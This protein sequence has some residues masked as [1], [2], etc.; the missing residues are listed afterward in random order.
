[1]KTIKLYWKRLKSQT[2]LAL[3]KLQIFFGAIS[4]G[5]LA[6][7][8]IIDQYQTA[9]DWKDLLVKIA[10]GCAG[11]AA[12]LNFGTTDKKLQKDV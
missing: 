7:V 4:A 3:K 2:P 11:A 12:S 8:L 10:I 9:T 5:C 1:M 6:M